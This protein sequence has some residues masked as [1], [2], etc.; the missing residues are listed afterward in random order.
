MEQIKKYLDENLDGMVE[1]HLMAWF[2]KEYL[3]KSKNCIEFHMG[4]HDDSLEIEGAE[5]VL[6]RE[7]NA[8]EESYLI[9]IFHEAV[10]NNMEF[11]NNIAV[12]FWNT[13][14]QLEVCGRG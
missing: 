8:D 10:I 6:K 2:T 4:T 7:L 1:S 14:E 11:N 9:D 13:L 3:G 5:G 12:G